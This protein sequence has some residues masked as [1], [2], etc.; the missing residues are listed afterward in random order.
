M[1][2][3]PLAVLAPRLARAPPIAP[4]Q[5]SRAPAGR[6][7]QW[8]SSDANFA[9]PIPQHDSRCRLCKPQTSDASRTR[10][11]GCAC[12][13]CSRSAHRCRASISSAGATETHRDRSHCTGSFPLF[14]EALGSAD[15]LVKKT[16]LYR[17]RRHSRE[18]RWR[19]PL[20][21]HAYASSAGCAS[22][23]SR[24]TRRPRRRLRT[25]TR[26]SRAIIWMAC[27]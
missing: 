23:G 1:W 7:S 6:N 18:V 26:T 4:A 25:T 2:P 17:E 22:R 12:L 11:A 10:H 15:F 19:P 27:A 24:R 20:A 8:P 14:C 9:A 3:K 5:H 16:E 21:A 13:P